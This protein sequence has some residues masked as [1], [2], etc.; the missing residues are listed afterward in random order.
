MF[1]IVFILIV[2]IFIVIIVKNVSEWNSNNNSPILSIDAT[3]K[4]KR[5]SISTTQLPNGGDSS[6]AQGFHTT[7]TAYHYVTFQVENGDCMEFRVN[8]TEY[9]SLSDGYKGKLSF[10]GSRYVRFDRQE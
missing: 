4:S 10:Q 9:A 2:V 3:V 8:S 5:I 1:N 6:G 7:T